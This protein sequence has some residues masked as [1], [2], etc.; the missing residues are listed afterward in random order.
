[1]GHS[2]SSLSRSS[3]KSREKPSKVLFLL[4]RTWAVVVTD[5][6]TKARLSRPRISEDSI[7]EFNSQYTICSCSQC[8]WQEALESDYLR[9]VLCKYLVGFMNIRS[10]IVKI[11]TLETFDVI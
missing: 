3:D 10:Q 4:H 9:Y 5:K 8:E 11:R 1:M 6:W 7:S 2:F